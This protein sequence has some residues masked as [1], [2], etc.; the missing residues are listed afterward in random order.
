MVEIKHVIT[1][2]L[3]IH[4][5]PAAQLVKAASAFPCDIQIGGSDKMV[6]AKSI[7]G[8]M[9]LA[10]KQG[11]ELIMSFDGEQEEE[12]AATLGVFLKENL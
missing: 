7:I 9:A 8:V 12:A 5:R 4:A 6:E 1:D 11:D 10:K 3:G 2:E